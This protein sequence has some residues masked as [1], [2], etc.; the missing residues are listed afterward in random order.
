MQTMG[1][2]WDR[3]VCDAVLPLFRSW[4]DSVYRLPLFSLL[5]LSCCEVCSSE[6]FGWV[7]FACFLLG[8]FFLASFLG[9]EVRP[10]GGSMSAGFFL[11][12][13]GLAIAQKFIF[14]F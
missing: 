8:S 13:F 1:R 7:S 6:Y 3:V 11:W 4:F 2:I 5:Q 12:F 9:W 10:V 14:E